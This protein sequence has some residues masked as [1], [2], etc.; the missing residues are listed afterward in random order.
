[1]LESSIALR[2]N[3]HNHIT[4]TISGLG[5]TGIQEIK[6]LETIHYRMNKY[7]EQ[8]FT[9]KKLNGRNSYDTK[10]SLL[11]NVAYNIV[12]MPGSEIVRDSDRTTANLL[13]CGEHYGYRQPIAGIVSRIREEVSDEQMKEMDIWSIT[14]LHD[15]ILCADGFPYV[16]RSSRGG[17]GFLLVGYWSHPDIQWKSNDTFA[18]FC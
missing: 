16:L 13:D 17:E 15:H 6:R 12:L 5:L 7:A 11:A 4:F 8:V 14:A 9:E 3:K 1:M 18:F 10:H 2:R